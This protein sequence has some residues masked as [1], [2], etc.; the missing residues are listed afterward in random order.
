MTVVSGQP[1]K[2]EVM[3]QGRHAEH[4]P[5][6]DPE[7]DHLDHHRQGDDDEQAADDGQEQL[8]IH[9]QTTAR[10]GPTPMASEPV[11][12]MKIRAGAAFHHRK[13]RQAPASAMEARAR[14]R[15]EATW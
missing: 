12:P 5:A 1:S 7:A 13:P 11:S 14:S 3:V 8:E 4:A 10:P 2:L 15:A 9:L 6:E